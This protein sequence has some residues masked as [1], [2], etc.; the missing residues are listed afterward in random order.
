MGYSIETVKNLIYRF[1]EI[2][3]M[4]DYDDETQEVFIF[5]WYKYNW[6]KVQRLKLIS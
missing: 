4:I 2:H 3:K 6:S 1:K 5:N